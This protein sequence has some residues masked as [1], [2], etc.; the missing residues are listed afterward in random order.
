MSIRSNRA[1]Q[2]RRQQAAAA[3]EK[4]S[5]LIKGVVVGAL[6]FALAGGMGLAALAGMG[7]QRGTPAP[8][9]GTPT[10]APASPQLA[11][12]GA[13]A[14]GDALLVAQ[15]RAGTPT[16][17]LYQDYQCP[18]CKTFE[19][20][21]GGML[22]EGARAGD[23]TLQYKTMTFMDTNLGNT[24]STRA[25]LAVACAADLEAHVPFSAEVFARQSGRAGFSDT[26]LREAIPA[27]VDLTGDALAGF[28]SC[29]DGRAAQEFVT[30]V[31]ASA[32]GDGVQGTPSLAI[33]GRVVDFDQVEPWSPDGLKAYVLAN[34]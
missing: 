10:L 2:S 26:L 34:A 32:A 13:N 6:A 18:N 9:A 1:E 11:P 3:R 15:G 24:A 28:Q 8:A 22:V 30:A 29:Y 25:A 14:A 31:D 12:R 16:L 23:W 4:R 5:R 27:A 33:N 19:E 7:A 20:G 17:T 21:F